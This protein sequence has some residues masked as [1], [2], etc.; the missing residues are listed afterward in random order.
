GPIGPLVQPSRSDD[1]GSG[2]RHGDEEESGGDREETVEDAMEVEQNEAQEEEA[3]TF[4]N[5]LEI[6]RQLRTEN[7]SLRRKVTSLRLRFRL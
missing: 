1:D 4:D 2:N 7:R 3:I 5:S 6:V